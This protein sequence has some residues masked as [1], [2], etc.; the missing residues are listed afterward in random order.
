MWWRAGIQAF[1]LQRRQEGAEAVMIR[2]FTCEHCGKE[3][4]SVRSD[5]EAH[6]EMLQL[7]GDLPED[8]Q[9]ILCEECFQQVTAWMKQQELL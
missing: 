9:A 3:F 5:E 8:D 2:A 1:Q 6:A 7:F 4:L